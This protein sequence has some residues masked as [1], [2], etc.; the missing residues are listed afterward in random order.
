M[1]SVWFL[2]GVTCHC[3]LVLT[4]A[5]LKFL[6][7]LHVPWLPVHHVALCQKNTHYY[8]YCACHAVLNIVGKPDK[9][10]VDDCMST[11]I[12]Q[13]NASPHT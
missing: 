8:T 3:P 7:A 5:L 13:D 12:V 6:A 9:E 2:C 1:A 10:H 4:V 11:E